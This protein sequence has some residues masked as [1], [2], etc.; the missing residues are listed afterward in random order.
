MA[1][2]YSKITAANIRTKMNRQKN[3]VTS[4]VQLAREFGINTTYTRYFSG[5]RTGERAPQ[6]FVNQVKSL[7][8]ENTYNQL[9]RAECVNHSYR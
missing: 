3:P 6:S 5:G 2:Q 7:V 1:N 4:V 9:R 8:G